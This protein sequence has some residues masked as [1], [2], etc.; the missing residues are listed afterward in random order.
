MEVSILVLMDVLLQFNF[1]RHI[2]DGFYGF[3]P[4]FNGCASS[5][6]TPSTQSASSMLSFNPCFNGCASSISKMIVAVIVV[7]SFNPCFNGCASSIRTMMSIRKVGIGVSILVL[8][9]VLLQ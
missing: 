3:N 6:L 2:F 9:D 7:I 4:C 1:G 8:M 5:M